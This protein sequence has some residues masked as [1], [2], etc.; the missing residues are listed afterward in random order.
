MF[1]GGLVFLFFGGGTL[2]TAL[3]PPQEPEPIKIITELRCTKCDYK[4]T[5]DF[6]RGDYIFLETDSCVKCKAPAYIWAIYSD[7]P[8]T[9]AEKKILAEDL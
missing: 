8:L 5:R 4:A 9:D 2:I 7:P 1:L 3:S 6:K